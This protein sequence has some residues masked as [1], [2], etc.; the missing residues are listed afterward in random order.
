MRASFYVRNTGL[1]HDELRL[2]RWRQVDFKN[3]A[4]IV[5]QS[6]TEHGT[7]RPVPMNQRAVKAMEDWAAQFPKRKPAHFVFPSEKV[8]ISGNDEIPQVFDTD[9]TKAITSWEVS[10]TTAR[11][12]SGVQI[13]FHAL[14]HSCC[15]RLLER[16]AA[17][18][19]VATIMGWSP[20][21]AMRMAKRYG[22]I[23][24]SIQR[25]AVALLDAQPP[26]GTGTSSVLAPT[27]PTVQ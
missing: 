8:G 17:F 20:G 23:G 14:R 12:V 27:H 7:G 11:D 19:T 22:H 3:Q 16:G 5:G 10:W 24:K 13:R 6:K 1:R 18:A 26:Q 2:L 9:P 21:T 4:I 15:T 25:D